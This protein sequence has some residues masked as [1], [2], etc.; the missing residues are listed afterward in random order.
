MKIKRL[1]LQTF[2][3]IFDYFC[4]IAYGQTSA[5]IPE[6]QTK[7]LNQISNAY[8]DIRTYIRENVAPFFVDGKSTIQ[9]G[10]NM[11]NNFLN[12]FGVFSPFPEWFDVVYGV[13]EGIAAVPVFWD[14]FYTDKD[15]NEDFDEAN[16][17]LRSS[18]NEL[19]AKATEDIKKS[20]CTSKV[21]SSMNIY[22]NAIMSNITL[23]SKTLK[24][25]FLNDAKNERTSMANIFTW[26]NNNATICNNKVS[27]ELTLNCTM[28]A[29]RKKNLCLPRNFTNYF[30]R[31]F[32]FK[33][34]AQLS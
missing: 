20:A 22:T 9:F 24:T 28:T 27:N 21:I 25:A 26:F 23:A 6:M 11:G 10:L 29:V 14:R 13:A 1:R 4:Q 8:P 12:K 2:K 31:V 16:V 15:L 5:T 34:M 19:F 33:K 17:E 7:I 18:I 30:H 3:H 32:R